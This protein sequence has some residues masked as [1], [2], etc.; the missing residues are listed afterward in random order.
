MLRKVQGHCGL[1]SRREEVFVLPKP[2]SAAVTPVSSKPQPVYHKNPIDHEYSQYKSA[3]DSQSEGEDS[4]CQDPAKL[5]TWNE[6]SDV[7]SGEPRAGERQMIVDGT[8]VH[9]VELVSGT[10]PSSVRKLQSSS[11]GSAPGVSNAI[12]SNIPEIVIE[13]RPLSCDNSQDNKS[14]TPVS[15]SGAWSQQEKSSEEEMETDTS[16][17]ACKVKSEA[18]VEMKMEIPHKDGDEGRNENKG[19]SKLEL[20]PSAS[21]SELACQVTKSGESDLNDSSQDN[22]QKEYCLSSS[23]DNSQDSGRGGNKYGNKGDFSEGDAG[24]L[25]CGSEAD[26][27]T[28]EMDVDDDVISASNQTSQS[29]IDTF[30]MSGQV[31]KSEPAAENFSAVKEIIEIHAGEDFHEVSTVRNSPSDLYRCVSE[32][33]VPSTENHD[34]D[35]EKHTVKGTQEGISKCLE[36]EGAT[37]YQQTPVMKTTHDSV[38]L[39]E[40]IDH[41]Q[42]SSKI[43][44]GKD[45]GQTDH[46]I[47]SASDEYLQVQTANESV[48]IKDE[49]DIPSDQG[50]DNGK[51]SCEMSQ[52]LCEPEE[53]SVNFVTSGDSVSR[54]IADGAG[55][56]KEEGTIRV[57]NCQKVDDAIAKSDEEKCKTEY[58]EKSDGLTG[59]LHQPMETSGAIQAENISGMETVTSD[60][61]ENEGVSLSQNV[62]TSRDSFAHIESAKADTQEVDIAAH[63]DPEL[64]RAE[65]LSKCRAGLELCA[66]RFSSHY[67]SL[68]RLAHMCYSTKVSE[69]Y[70]TS[71]LFY[72]FPV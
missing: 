30:V 60:V 32:G 4:K 6:R 49:L 58:K 40:F 37:I 22:S 47:K 28:D 16:E 9:G 5:R 20:I 13:N 15:A 18:S 19:D 50:R 33:F 42:E 44:S 27:D 31:Y 52:P 26:V 65:L 72:Q 70:V 48:P 71:A 17:V 69:S 59:Q 45:D 51:R 54:N 67:K 8:S 12:D 62:S 55:N 23:Q 34:T 1:Y 39:T 63:K 3:S 14:A 64:L 7:M 21:Y 53:V 2:A 61:V 25:S 24:I 38:F 57:E 41:S 66:S 35:S 29:S 11:A 10:E 56:L 46:S 68:Y 43:E 36:S